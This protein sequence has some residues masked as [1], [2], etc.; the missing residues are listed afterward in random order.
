MGI[1]GLRLTS[2]FLIVAG[3]LAAQESVRWKNSPVGASRVKQRTPGRSHYLLQT[4]GLSVEDVAKALDE[5]NGWIVRVLPAAGYVI[6]APDA[7]DLSSA[8]LGSAIRMDVTSKI[9]TALLDGGLF[10]FFLVE[11]HPD[12]APGDAEALVIQNRLILHQR[13]DLPANQLLVEGSLDSAATLAGWDEVAYIFP[14]SDDLVNGLP[15]YP[16]ASALT[17][18]GSIGQYIATVGAGWDGPGQGSAALTYSFEALTGKLTETQVTT[19]IQRALGEWSKAASV[20]F[21]LID[22]TT[23]ARNLNFLF[24]SGAHGDAYPFDGPGKVLAHTY[25]PAPS[26]PEPTAG[27]LHFDGDESWQIGA[28]IDLFSVVLH[29]LGHALGLGHADTPGAVM[30]PY[31]QRASKLSAADIAAVQTLYAPAPGQTDPGPPVSPGTPT[32]P[33]AGPLTIVVPDRVLTAASSIELAGTTYGGTGGAHVTWNSDK[34]QSGAATGVGSWRATVGPL[35]SGS[36]TFRFTAT[37]QLGAKASGNVVVTQNADAGNP[38]ATPTPAPTP[39]PTPGPTPGPT[40]VPAPA[41]PANPPP[42]PTPGP[43]PAPTPTPTPPPAAPST[44]VYVVIN[45]PARS[46]A[47]QSPLTLS[48]TASSS[49]GIARVKWVNSNGGSGIAT[50]TSTW[51]TA[52]PLQDGDN[53]IRVTAM[54]TDATEASQTVVVSY[55]HGSPDV[56]APSLTITYPSTTSVSTNRAVIAITGTAADTVGVAEVSWTN[57]TGPAGIA[58]GTTNWSTGDIPLLVGDNRI[59]LRAKDAAGNAGW[60]ALVVTR[61]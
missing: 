33:G 45:A 19:Q 61:R 39:T 53:S 55:S 20:S 52:I 43:T 32:G 31:Y 56:T 13:P 49:R 46:S 23:A 11:F 24:A 8:G 6:S 2:A 36:T 48:G 26:N 57:S 22:K 35:A 7:A 41:A 25:F 9:S 12:V 3:L 51:T 27:D 44:P 14:A 37:D 47:A 30:Y 21:T 18:T 1:C 28:D 17:L 34:G 50:G 40:P 4:A 59:T 16:C 58:N 15:V 5:R 29:E 10:S 60:R 54:A 42:N 38:G